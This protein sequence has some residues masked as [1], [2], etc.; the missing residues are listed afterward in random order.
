MDSYAT[1]LT[2]CQEHLILRKDACSRAISNQHRVICCSLKT[3]Y[4][5]HRIKPATGSC[6][7]TS[8]HSIQSMNSSETIGKVMQQDE[9]A[10]GVINAKSH[11]RRRSAQQTDVTGFPELVRDIT[12]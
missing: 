1:G 11:W 6:N 9:R 8:M 12:T 10:G 5:V 3:A 7:E 4:I 2:F